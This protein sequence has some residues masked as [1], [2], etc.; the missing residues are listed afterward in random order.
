M[1]RIP[2]VLHYTFGMARDFGGKPWSLVHHVCL[3]SAIER[4]KPD[5][6]YFYCQFEPATA[7]W[8]L[9]RELVTVVKIE[10]PREIFG[11][12]LKHVAHKSDVVRLQKLIQ[13]GGIYLDA[14][15]FVQPGASMTCWT[16]PLFWAAKGRTT[17]TEW[18]MRSSWPSPVPR[19]F[20]AGWRNTGHSA[21]VAATNDS[22]TNIPSNCPRGL[23]GRIPMKSRSLPPKA[24]FWPLWTDDHLDWIFQFNRPIPLRRS[25]YANHL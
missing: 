21:P 19:S 7:W 8:R 11:R 5:K 20:A 22:G 12:P 18:R 2:K 10:A 16:I 25:T 4:I 13:H 23:P 24:F 17:N 14:D 15:V 6:I 9:S 1:S 3:K